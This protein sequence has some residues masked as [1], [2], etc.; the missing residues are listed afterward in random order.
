MRGPARPEVIA[1]FGPTGVGKTAVAIAL[2]EVLQARGE[3]PPVAVSA[4]ALQV[5]EGLAALTGAAT[6]EE[7]ARLEAPAGPPPL[8]P[9]RFLREQIRIGDVP[10]LRRAR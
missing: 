5:Y 3:R 9:Q 8:Y 4:D 2:A 6:A 10:A 1:L 7:R